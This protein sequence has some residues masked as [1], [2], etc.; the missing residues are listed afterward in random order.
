VYGFGG[1]TVTQRIVFEFLDSDGSRSKHWRK[2]HAALRK[3]GAEHITEPTGNN[4]QVLTAVLPA[5]E[6]AN[7]AVKRLIALPG[8]GR[9]ELDQMVSLDGFTDA[10]P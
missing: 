3:L 9:A 6:A 1:S 8:I 7:L 10:E 4:P 2:A 5:V